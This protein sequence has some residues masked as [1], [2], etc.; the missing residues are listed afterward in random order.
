VNAI[1]N[2]LYA[3]LEAECRLALA[4]LGLDPEMGV[5]HMDSPNRDSLACD[6]MEVIRP[7]VD[8]YVL[9]WIARQPL[10]R[11]WFFE[12][13]NGNCRLMAAL[14]SE[15]AETSPTWAR[16]VAP[17]AEWVMK[18][19]ASTTRTRKSISPTRLTQDHK[20]AIKVGVIRPELAVMIRQPN[21]CNVCG[22]EIG[23]RQRS[24]LTCSLAPSAERLTAVAAKGL[25]ASHSPEAQ[26]KRSKKHH[27][28][29]ATR[30]AWKPSDQPVWLTEECYV[31]KV[32]PQLVSQSSRGIARALNVSLSYAIQIRHGRVVPHPRHWLVLARLGGYSS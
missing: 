11:C 4:T 9:N 5:L 14:A 7:E 31:S 32:K 3:L 27:D 22:T 20:R 28:L 17:V 6:L 23:G 25:I 19:I 13:R 15:L 8:A 26:A 12:E 29:H 2:Y 1:L 18:E 24:C 21:V 30:R 10:K 16:L